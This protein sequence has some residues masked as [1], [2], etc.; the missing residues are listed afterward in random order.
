[1]GDPSGIADPELKRYKPMGMHLK[2][3][4]G[5][6]Q[7][8]NLTFLSGKGRYGA[9]ME[10]AGPVPAARP[11]SIES[12]ASA[13]GIDQVIDLRSP[14]F[15]KKIL[16]AN[17]LEYT[18]VKADWSSLFDAFIY[19]DAFSPSTPDKTPVL[20]PCRKQLL[21]VHLYKNILPIPAGS[22]MLKQKRRYP[23]PQ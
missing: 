6:D 21:P 9:W 18:P 12:I 16:V 19:L 4:L 20:R 15:Y 7:V 3:A 1:M 11:G 5:K 14:A 23:L 13:K 10:A 8:F 2:K 17:A 22:S